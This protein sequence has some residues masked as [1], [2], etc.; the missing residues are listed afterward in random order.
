MVEVVVGEQPKNEGHRHE[1]RIS[2]EKY[3]IMYGGTIT[4]LAQRIH[5]TIP[6]HQVVIDYHKN[7]PESFARLEIFATV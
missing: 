4:Y 3:Y 5:H 6:Y 7:L 2:H 1:P